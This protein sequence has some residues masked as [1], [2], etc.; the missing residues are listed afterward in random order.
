MKTKEKILSAALR[1]F[2]EYGLDAVTLRQI[3]S[4]IGISQGNLN[5][6]FPKKEAIVEALYQQLVAKISIDFSQFEDT[7]ITLAVLFAVGKKTLLALYDYRFIMLD[8]VRVMK[9][10]PNIQQHFKELNVLR[11]QQYAQLFQVLEQEQLMQPEAFP[12]QYDYLKIQFSILG[13]YWIAS[14][15]VLRDDLSEEAKID[16]YLKILISSLYPNLTRQ[17]KKEFLKL[18]RTIEVK[19]HE[20]E[21]AL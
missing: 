1:L 2:N 14:A 9:Q 19:V 20:D 13:D 11:Q 4:E 15:E 7:N 12:K 3:A 18:L 6:H 21:T 8:F 10:H 17:G 16:Y 5:Y